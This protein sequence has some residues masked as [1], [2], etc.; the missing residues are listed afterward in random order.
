MQ[1]FWHGDKHTKAHITYLIIILTVVFFDITVG[2]IY[3][4]FNVLNG[5]FIIKFLKLQI[6]LNTFMLMTYLI[7]ILNDI[8]VSVEMAL[9]AYFNLTNAR[10]LYIL[11]MVI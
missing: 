7:V 8:H 11:T 10:L 1:L 2:Y 6:Y 4:K 9:K 3:F 5:N